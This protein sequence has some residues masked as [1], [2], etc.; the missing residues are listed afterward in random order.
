MGH[1]TPKAYKNLQVRLD[2]HAQGAPE[3]ETLYKI[4]EVLFTEKEAELVA[5][6]PFDYF[7]IKKASQRFKKN[8]A[9]T[10]KILNDLAD[11]GILLDMEN[12]KE[13][14]F[15]LA[16]TMAGFFEFSLMRTD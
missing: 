13:R 12:K 4:L 9:E 15:I 16:P 7:T 6:L 10:E 1:I 3:S 2:R 8:I 14:V 11:K 5:K